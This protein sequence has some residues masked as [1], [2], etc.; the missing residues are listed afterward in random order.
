MS[1]TVTSDGQVANGSDEATPRQE[2]DDDATEQ[3]PVTASPARPRRR[4]ADLQGWLRWTLLMAT[5]L[6]VA[7]ASTATA[8]I[9]E[10][11][12]EPVHA[13]RAEVL[14]DLDA[15]RSFG[16]LREDR[17]LTTQLVLITGRTVLE[18][19]AAEHELDW[20]DLAENTEAELLESSEIIQI[21]VEDSDRDRAVALADD[22]ATEYLTHTIDEEALEAESL[23]R[24]ELIDSE[25]RLGAVSRQ[26]NQIEVD[27]E[28]GQTPVEGQRLLAEHS[29]L[30][31][32]IASQRAELSDL[33]QRV[34][35]SQRGSR[36]GETYLLEDPVVPDLVRA[37]ITGLLLG[38]LLGLGAAIA[39]SRP[40]RADPS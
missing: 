15:D 9:V 40:R 11:R 2:P 39:L 1:D 36:V 7:L 17:R 24:N 34:M 26:L 14:Y 29:S 20:H 18:P 5:M 16:F 37:G 21:E 12:K 30:L 4:L 33:Q 10:N 13:A 27:A 19:V 6:V 8:L 32:T 35:N 23:L 31:T 3:L 22:I 25:V 28:T 38:G